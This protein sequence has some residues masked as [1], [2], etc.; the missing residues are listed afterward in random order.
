MHGSNNQAMPE[1]ISLSLKRSSWENIIHVLHEVGLGEMSEG[2]QGVYF[3][4]HGEYFSIGG[5]WAQVQSLEAQLERN[6][7]G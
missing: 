3:K 2:R 7:S 5:F 6:R 4:E 1:R